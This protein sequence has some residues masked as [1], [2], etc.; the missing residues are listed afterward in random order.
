MPLGIHDDFVGHFL[1]EIGIEFANLQA[2][3]NQVPVAEETLTESRHQHYYEQ[4]LFRVN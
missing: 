3:G 2:H 1:S 4:T